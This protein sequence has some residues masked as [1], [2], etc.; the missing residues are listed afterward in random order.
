MRLILNVVWLVFGGFWLFVGYLVAGVLL[1]IP[2]ITIP[3]AI[4]SFRIAVYALWPFG[5]TVVTKPSAGVGSFLGNVIWFVL[6]GWWLAIAHIVSAVA[7][8]V[9]IVGIPLALAD[10]K[11][12]PISLAPLGKD[13][14]PTQRGEFDAYA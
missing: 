4:A 9:T 2:I 13:I 10:L 1:C 14:V 7:L 6:A 5:R 3:W 8:A 12:V 11:M